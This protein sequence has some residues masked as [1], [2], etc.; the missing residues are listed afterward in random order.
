MNLDREWLE[1]M[2]QIEDECKSISVGGLASDVGLLDEVM[3]VDD[4][5]MGNNEVYLALLGHQ[6]GEWWYGVGS[7]PNEGHPARV[8]FDPYQVER[9]EDQF[10][11]V[12]GFFHTH[13][14]MNS[15]PSAIDYNTMFG[16]TVSFGKPMACLIEGID[17]L[18]GHWFLDDEHYHTTTEV[19][20][21]GNIFV[22]RF[23]S[24]DEF[25]KR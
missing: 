6:E 24:E 18:S 11:D 1:K 7:W 20:R 2:A 3:T 14:S 21:F 10:R 15:R 19:Y 12:I 17:G 9:R 22:G 13:P 4:A 16:W 8:D 5:V 25:V 23:P